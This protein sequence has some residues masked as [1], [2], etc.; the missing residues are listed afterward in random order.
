MRAYGAV[1]KGAGINIMNL[2]LNFGYKDV[3]ALCVGGPF[4]TRLPVAP[5]ALSLPRDPWRTL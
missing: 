3:L 2:Q 4:A 5:L 1:Y